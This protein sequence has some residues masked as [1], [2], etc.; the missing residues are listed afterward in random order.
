[1]GESEPHAAKNHSDQPNEK[2]YPCQGK[3]RQ[4]AEDVERECAHA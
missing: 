3:N 2:E 4:D 1:M